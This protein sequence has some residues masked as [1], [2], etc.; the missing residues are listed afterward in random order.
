MKTLIA[1]LLTVIAPLVV[2]PDYPAREI[3]SIC[4]FRCFA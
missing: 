2:A 4:N 3:R 1:L